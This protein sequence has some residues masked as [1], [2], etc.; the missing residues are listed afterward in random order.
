MAASYVIDFTVGWSFG[1][2]QAEMSAVSEYNGN[3][4]GFLARGGVTM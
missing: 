3:G 4:S 1:E 2:P